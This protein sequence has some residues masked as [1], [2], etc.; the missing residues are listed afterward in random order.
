[1]T[2]PKRTPFEQAAEGVLAQTDRDVVPDLPECAMQRHDQKLIQR[3]VNESKRELGQG[4]VDPGVSK[5]AFADRG[6]PRLA[7]FDVLTQIPQRGSLS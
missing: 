4:L 5:R 3:L 2:R 1:M 6:M 7:I